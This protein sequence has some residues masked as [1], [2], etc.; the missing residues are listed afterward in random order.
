MM[1]PWDRSTQGPTDFTPLAVEGQPAKIIRRRLGLAANREESPA[2]HL[3]QV[4]AQI[5]AAPSPRCARA[6]ACS[7]H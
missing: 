2:Q 1:G 6:I 3:R 4:R 7:F 5:V